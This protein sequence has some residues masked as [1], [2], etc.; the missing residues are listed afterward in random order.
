VLH[1]A[2]IGAATVRGPVG[3]HRALA[4]DHEPGARPQ[5]NTMFTIVF[6]RLAI[7]SWIF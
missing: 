3:S 2:A 6:H 5:G 1:D 4:I 7:N